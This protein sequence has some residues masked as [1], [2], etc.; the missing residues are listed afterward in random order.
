M[1]L[2]I[3]SNYYFEGVRRTSKSLRLHSATSSLSLTKISVP[4]SIEVHILLA[5][6]VPGSCTNENIIN[7]FKFIII[8]YRRSSLNTIINELA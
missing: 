1:E 4:T 8:N 6:L 3:S 7:N 5:G 2:E